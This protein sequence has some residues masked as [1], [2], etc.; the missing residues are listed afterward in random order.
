M[1]DA[2]AVCEAMRRPRMRFVS[3][4]SAQQQAVLH[5]HHNRRLLVGQHT[6]L[7]NHT[8]GLLIELCIV[9]AVDSGAPSK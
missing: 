5:L 3:V 8:H 6:A 4:K 9:I 2:E 1:L 7:I